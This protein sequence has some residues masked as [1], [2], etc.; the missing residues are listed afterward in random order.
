MSALDPFYLV[1][2][3]IQDSVKGLQATFTR[4]ERLPPSATDRIVLSKELLS[5]CESIEWQ[6]EELDR[7]TGVAERD[8][9]RF[10]IDLVEIERRKKWIAST[11]SQ[12]HSIRQKLQTAAE[13]GSGIRPGIATSNRRELMRMDEH[14]L[15]KSNH[16]ADNGFVTDESGR[17]ALIMKEQEEDLDDLSETVMRLGGVGLTIHEELTSQGILIDELGNDMD[18]TATRLDFI[19]KR[20][21]T[22]MKKAGWKGQVM[23]VVFLIALLLILTFLV[24]SG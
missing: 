23:I 22:V 17:Q 5:G 3:E 4:W 12:V 9:A 13:N 2:E 7:A 1:K 16:T 14:P 24:F 10:S 8:P 19:Q 18:S 11:F 6:V 21:A 20:V 15:P